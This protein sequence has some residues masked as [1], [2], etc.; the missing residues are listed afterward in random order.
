MMSH[1]VE[2]INKS[3]IKHFSK[4]HYHNITAL[5]HVQLIANACGGRGGV[6]DKSTLCVVTILE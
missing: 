2:I 5:S 4:L 6:K 1:R 3:E